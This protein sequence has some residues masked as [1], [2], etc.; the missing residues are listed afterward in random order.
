MQEAPGSALSGRFWRRHNHSRNAR[1]SLVSHAV[2][3]R[4]SKMPRRTSLL[5]VGCPNSSTNQP[6]AKTA[7]GAGVCPQILGRARA[8]GGTLGADRGPRSLASPFLPKA[9]K[10]SARDDTQHPLVLGPRKGVTPPALA[11]AALRRAASSTPPQSP[12][13]REAGEHQSSIEP[14]ALRT[15]LRRPSAG[16]GLPRSVPWQASQRMLR[17]ANVPFRDTLCSNGSQRC[18]SWLECA[19]AS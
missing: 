2:P 3:A 17:R 5:A 13:G 16:P 9:Q 10:G 6:R 15:L 4:P 11:Y 18:R 7:A 19:Q 12:A 1:T 14:L 8:R